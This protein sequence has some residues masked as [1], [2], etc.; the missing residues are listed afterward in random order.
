MRRFRREI[1]QTNEPLPG[2]G[3]I[4]LPAQGAAAYGAPALSHS[5]GVSFPPAPAPRSAAD[6]P[7]PP[8][9]LLTARDG[10]A[11]PSGS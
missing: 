10:R 3:L 6:G 1:A 2:G 5:Y 4:P 11:A 8:S 7:R 9:R